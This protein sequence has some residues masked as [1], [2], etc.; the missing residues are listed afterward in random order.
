MHIRPGKYLSGWVV[1]WVAG[2][3]E[4]I[5]NSAQLKLEL[6]LSLAIR[7]LFPESRA[8]CLYTIRNFKLVQ[9]NLT[10]RGTIP[11]SPANIFIHISGLVQVLVPIK[12]NKG[13]I[14]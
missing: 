4:N 9:K 5:A 14:P 8:K 3:A 12:L 13:T 7:V 6:G 10:P 11:R 1:G 2:L